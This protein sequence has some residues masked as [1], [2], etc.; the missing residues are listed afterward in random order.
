MKDG[1][2]LLQLRAISEDGAS[3]AIKDSQGR[4][5]MLQRADA[6]G[7]VPQKMEGLRREKIWLDPGKNAHF[8]LLDPLEE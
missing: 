8:L 4:P 3:L 1:Q 5:F 6:I 2:V 7:S